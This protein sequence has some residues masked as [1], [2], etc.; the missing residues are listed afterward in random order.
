[1]PLRV[2]DWLSNAEVKSILS[3]DALSVLKK[4]LK[5]Q[6][7]H[8]VLYLSG[9]TWYCTWGHIVRSLRSLDGDAR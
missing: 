7:N 3:E 9:K 1:M 5:G 6:D 4:T 2:D 8:E